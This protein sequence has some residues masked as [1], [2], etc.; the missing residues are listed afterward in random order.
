M[1]V[2]QL[3]I[4]PGRLSDLE[5][6]AFG[7]KCENSEHANTYKYGCPWSPK[8]ALSA[9]VIIGVENA[10]GMYSIGMAPTLSLVVGMKTDDCGTWKSHLLFVFSPK[11]DN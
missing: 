11:R 1:L 8:I 7:T 6:P 9:H 2:F 4:F 3:Y 10:W 5:K